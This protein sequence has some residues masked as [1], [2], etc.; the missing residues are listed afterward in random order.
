MKVLLLNLADPKEMGLLPNTLGALKKKYPD[1]DEKYGGVGRASLLWRFVARPLIGNNSV[2]SVNLMDV[3]ERKATRQKIGEIQTQCRQADKVI[4]GV[5]GTYG[6]TYHARNGENHSA[7]NLGSYADLASCMS[8]LLNAPEHRY[9]LCLSMCYAA[10]S[11]NFEKDHSDLTQLSQEDIENTFAFRFYSSLCRGKRIRMTACVGSVGFDR[12][13][14]RMWV[15][16]ETGVRA[17]IEKDEIIGEENALVEQ[18]KKCA[19]GPEKKE[20]LNKVA[21]SM[22][23]RAGLPS[24]EHARARKYGKLVYLY[25]NDRGRCIVMSKNPEPKVIYNQQWK[26]Q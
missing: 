10:R 21:E 4:L 19:K 16:T 15:L 2:E 26:P 14:G 3:L 1:L 25:D 23:K 8:D 24:T 5:H 6:D 11:W 7:E 12:L 18:L 17:E 13:T 20:L 22:N 9:N